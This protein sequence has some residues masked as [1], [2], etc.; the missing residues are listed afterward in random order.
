MHPILNTWT[1][2]MGDV[3]IIWD[4]MFWHI[5]EE[6]RRCEDRFGLSKQLNSHSFLWQH[7]H[8]PLEMYLNFRKA[9]GFR[10]K[11]RVLFGKPDNL[12]PKLD[13]IGRRLWNLHANR[14]NKPK[15]A[16]R[17]YVTTQTVFSVIL[18][19]IVGFCALS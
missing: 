6:E 10:E 9:N 18:L 8:F 12:N 16:M 15:L 3:L 14:N 2:T 4:R 17:Q 11:W 5:R 7:F 1:R 19:F 13:G